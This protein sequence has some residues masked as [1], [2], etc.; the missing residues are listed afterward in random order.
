MSTVISGDTG[1]DKIAPGAIEFADLPVGS[2]LQVVQGIYSTQVSTT[3]TTYTDTGLTATITPKFSTSKVLILISC[4]GVGKGG[5]SWTRLQ[6]AKNGS[7]F[8][9]MET[10]IGA[11]TSAGDNFIGSVCTDYLDSP[12]TTSA[13]TYKVQM[14]AGNGATAYMNVSS[15]EKS[16]I[17]L[18]EIAA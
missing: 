2:V 7:F 12:A 17:T 9:F 16:S 15:I 11:N 1:I 18:M 3:S 13:I 8:S 4:N 5:G 10:Y 14:S 6:I